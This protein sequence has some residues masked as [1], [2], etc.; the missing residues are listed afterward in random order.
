MSRAKSTADDRTTANTTAMKRESAAETKRHVCHVLTFLADA[1]APEFVKTAIREAIAEA[2]RRAD[3]TI[4]FSMPTTRLQRQL[5]YIFRSWPPEFNL[6]AT[7]YTSTAETHHTPAGSPPQIARGADATP[8]GKG[9]LNPLPILS[10]CEV[11]AGWMR[12]A[13][14]DALRDLGLREGDDVVI[15]T[16]EPEALKVG[17]QVLVYDQI[18]G[19]FAGAGRFQSADATGVTIKESDTNWIYSREGKNASRYTFH[20]IIEVKPNACPSPNQKRINEL[21][22]KLDHLDDRGDAW[23]NTTERFR[24]ESELFELENAS[25]SAAEEWPDVI[26]A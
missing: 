16:T 7:G 8:R 6:T 15:A 4:N 14:G 18:R 24:L 12:A 19:K 22:Y 3:V 13:W 2:A 1:R 5:Y 26:G 10:K 9:K 23:A 21:R 17:Q 20:R 11:T 25:T